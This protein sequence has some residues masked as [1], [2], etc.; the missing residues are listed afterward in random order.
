MRYYTKLLCLTNGFSPYAHIPAQPSREKKNISLQNFGIGTVLR[1]IYP[2]PGPIAGTLNVL[3]SSGDIL[4]H[5]NPRPYVSGPVL[6]LNSFLGCGWGTEER[7]SGYPFF[8]G[9][10]YVVIAVEESGYRITANGGVFQYL[11]KHRRTLTSD[12]VISINTDL[13]YV[14]YGA[15]SRQCI[16]AC[17]GST[18][19]YT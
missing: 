4:L 7:P 16:C 18:Y 5:F 6:V 15:V 9:T 17:S 14:Q 8:S 10:V 13:D 1:F 11:Y 19:M 3:S 12:L 2:S